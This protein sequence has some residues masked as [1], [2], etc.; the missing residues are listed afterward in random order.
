[1]I[2]SAGIQSAD[3]LVSGESRPDLATK[4]VTCNGEAGGACELRRLLSIVSPEM[5]KRILARMLDPKEFF[6]DY[7]I[8]ALSKYHLEHPYM[9]TL[10]GE[11]PPGWPM[12]PQ[13]QPRGKAFGG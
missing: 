8:R 7:G 10:D 5:L 6:G 3:E 1:M 2:H 11:E 12:S 13:S 4:D 9:L